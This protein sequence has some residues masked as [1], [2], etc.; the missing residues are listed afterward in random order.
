MLRDAVGMFHALVLCGDEKR[1]RRA[2]SVPHGYKRQATITRFV[3]AT[4]NVLDDQVMPLGQARSKAKDTLAAATTPFYGR[5]IK[6][7]SPV[8]SLA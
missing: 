5:V 8:A 2:H 3:F 4:F 6:Y 7:F 1:C